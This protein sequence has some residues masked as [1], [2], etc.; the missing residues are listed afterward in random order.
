MMATLVALKEPSLEDI[1]PQPLYILCGGQITL[2]EGGICHFVCC[3]MTKKTEEEKD[4]KQTE[5]EQ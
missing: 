3:V 5:K 4:T 1:M 2:R